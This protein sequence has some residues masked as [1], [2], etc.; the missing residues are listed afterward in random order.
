MEERRKLEL[1][2]II[3]KE[4]LLDDEARDYMREAFRDGILQETGTAITKVLP[5]VSRFTPD[6][7]RERKKEKVLGRLRAF[8]ERFYNLGDN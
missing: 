5:P 8:F 7:Q 1:D 2:Q 4:A 3:S 6:R